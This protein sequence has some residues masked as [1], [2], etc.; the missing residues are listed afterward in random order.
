MSCISGSLGGLEASSR[1]WGMVCIPSFLRHKERPLGWECRKHLRVFTTFNSACRSLEGASLRAGPRVHHSPAPPH[2]PEGEEGNQPAPSGPR[3]GSGA[4]KGVIRSTECCPSNCGQRVQPWQGFQF[5]SEVPASLG[6][7]VS[8]QP[9]DS[10]EL[11]A[12]EERGE[13]IGVGFM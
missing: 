12:G 2:F 9:L 1:S 13:R 11:G 3:T 8:L 7:H 4:E 10:P 6:V 5:L